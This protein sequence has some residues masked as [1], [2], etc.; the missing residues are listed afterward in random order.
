VSL[1]EI[2]STLSRR[3]A[4][5]VVGAVVTAL[6]GWVGIHPAPTYDAKSLITLRAPR[7]QNVPNQFNDGRPSL[8]LTGTLVAARLKSRSGEAQLR[9]DGVAGKYDLVP[10]NSGTTAT[11]LYI[12]ALLE[13]QV[14]TNSER[15]ALRSV[16]AIVSRFASELDAMQAEWDVP[17]AERISIAELAPPA[18][19]QMHVLK[20][21]VLLGIALLGGIGSAL[22]ALWLDGPLARWQRRRAWRAPAGRGTRRAQPRR[23]LAPR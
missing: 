15:D 5:L 3:W 10:R 13:I 20:D 12:I 2:V 22:A 18:I 9:R 21:R 19:L 4:V 8:A 11:P 17:G 1:R 16:K 6:A 14:V 7:S 23:M